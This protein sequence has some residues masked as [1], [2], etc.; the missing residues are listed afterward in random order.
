MILTELLA[1][2][3][4]YIMGAI[5]M[6]L[7]FTPPITVI[8]MFVISLVKYICAKVKNKKVP[9]TFSKNE[10]KKRG[11][12]LI[13]WSVAMVALVSAVVGFIVLMYYGIA[14]M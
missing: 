11:I 3:L 10:T 13:L 14:Y 9:N 4:G 8:V 5:M 1:T 12:K 2:A 6:L 7:F